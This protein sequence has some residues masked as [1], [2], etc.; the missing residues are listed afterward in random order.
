MF[1][2]FF[3]RANHLSA[4][5]RLVAD[6]ADFTSALALLAVHSAI[7]WSDAVAVKLVGSVVK[8]E[9][10]MTAAQTLEK[11][12]ASRRLNRDGLKHLKKLIQEKSKISYGD[13]RTTSDAAR[14]LSISAERFEIWA[15]KTLERLA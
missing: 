3:E 14:A 13:Q 5:R 10:H 15:I 7:S 9:D 11:R 4:A 12:C 2:V 6:D 1:E 8:N